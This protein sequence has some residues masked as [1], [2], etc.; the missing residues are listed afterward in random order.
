MSARRRL[1][2]AAELLGG[3]ESDDP[4]SYT[5]TLDGRVYLQAVRDGLR[6]PNHEHVG[7]ERALHDHAVSEALRFRLRDQRVVA[8]MGG[9]ALRR[10]EPTYRMVA[11]IARALTRAG[12]LVL[13]GGG[14]GAMEATHLGARVALVPDPVLDDAISAL[15]QARHAAFPSEATHLVHRR[16]ADGDPAWD[17]EV[18]AALH[19]WQRPAFAIAAETDPGAAASIGIPT[20]LYGHEPPTPFATHHAKYFENSIREDG[21]LAVATNGVMYAPG[22]PG[23][24]QEVFQDLAQNYYRTAGLFSPM[25]FLDVGQFWTVSHPVKALIDAI[26]PDADERNTHYVQT[27]ADV[28]RVLREFRVPSGRGTRPW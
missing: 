4:H 21:L 19:A 23:T 13:S 22:G 6:L 26:L 20:W 24:F 14:P 11:S 12:L 3:F 10:D 25:V 9:H 15:G 28:V 7:R 18:V 5:D 1:Y 27:G 8:I 2:T 16:A 17:Y